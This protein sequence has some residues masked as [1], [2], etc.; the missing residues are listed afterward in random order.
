MGLKMGCRTVLIYS[1]QDLSCHWESNR[2]DDGK[3][4]VAFRLGANIV[5]YATGRTTPKPRLT[6]V[7][8]I[9]EGKFDKRVTGA[10]VFHVAQIHL[11]GESPPAPR[12]MGKVLE[13]LHNTKDLG[14]DV[15]LKAETILLHRYSDKDIRREKFFYMHGRGEFNYSAEDAAKLRFT[16]KNGGLLF[17]DASCGKE[18][19]DKSFRKFAQELFPK[20]KLVRV[21]FEGKERDPIFGEEY[22]ETALT[23]ANIQCR[24]TSNGKMQDMAP[25]LEGIKI[26]GRWVVLYSRYDI[27]CALEHHTSPSCI[28]YSYD[29]AMRIASAVL[30][31]HL[32]AEIVR[33]SKKQ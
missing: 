25:F 31:Y 7:E 21:P 17:A 29:S 12:A 8:V 3:A 18:S 4:Q 32:K 22:N 30:R 9:D 15:S 2:L 28:G 19:F 26:D 16:L 1:P 10:G 24:T 33:P 14:L 27:G 5:A 13:R 20:E 11:P 23:P 6:K